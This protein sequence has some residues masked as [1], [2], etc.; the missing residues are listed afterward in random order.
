MDHGMLMHPGETH[1]EL[2]MAYYYTWKGMHKTVQN[3]YVHIATPATT[4]T[5]DDIP[6]WGHNISLNSINNNQSALAHIQDVCNAAKRV[7]GLIDFW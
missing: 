5:K 2:T 4:R 3:G 6:N 1:M 7:D